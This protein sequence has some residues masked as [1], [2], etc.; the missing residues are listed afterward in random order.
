MSRKH[1]KALKEEVR[2][3]TYRK[4]NNGCKTY[5]LTYGAE[6]IETIEL[7]N[8]DTM[9]KA[10]ALALINESFSEDGKPTAKNL[11]AVNYFRVA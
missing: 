4:P 9:T 1:R 2:S 3:Y 6:L 11:K 8:W 10:K 5:M 7:D